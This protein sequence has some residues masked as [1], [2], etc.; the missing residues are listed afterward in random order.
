MS[1][2]LVTLQLYSMT[3]RHQMFIASV[4]LFAVVLGIKK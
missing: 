1:E 3:L 2:A 4:H